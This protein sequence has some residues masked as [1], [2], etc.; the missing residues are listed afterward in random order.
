MPPQ[1]TRHARSARLLSL[2]R[3]CARLALDEIAV[4]AGLATNPR[5]PPVPER[6]ALQTAAMVATVGKSAG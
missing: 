3:T 6:N 2:R 5:R 1:R 4:F